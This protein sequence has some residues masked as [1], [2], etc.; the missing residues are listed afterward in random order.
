MRRFVF[1]FQYCSTSSTCDE[2]LAGKMFHCFSRARLHGA[3]DWRGASSRINAQQHGH[4]PQL[5]AGLRLRS[6]RPDQPASAGRPTTWVFQAGRAGQS[7]NAPRS[8]RARS[9]STAP[10]SDPASTTKPLPVGVAY[11][12]AVEPPRS[13]RWT[14]AR[15]RW[16]G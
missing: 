7:V 6:V 4:W 16:W 2:L 1:L 9:T 5:A 3:A 10:R 15:W 8:S 13:G 12:S 14:L 11:S